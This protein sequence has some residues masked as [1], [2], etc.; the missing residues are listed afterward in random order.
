[1]RHL[2]LLRHPP[3]DMAHE[4]AWM[5]RCVGRGEWAPLTEA[6][7]VELR[8]RMERVDLETGAPLFF[9]GTSTVRS[10]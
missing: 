9:Q 10:G 1:L 3:A 4:A 5:A 2:G 8:K 6:D 7:I